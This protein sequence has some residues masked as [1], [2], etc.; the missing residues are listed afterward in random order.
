MPSQSPSQPPAST[1]LSDATGAG[2]QALPEKTGKDDEAATV[3]ET[4]EKRSDAD[5]SRPPKVDI[6]MQHDADAPQYRTLPVRR[7]HGGALPE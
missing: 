1:R 5:A 2:G 3:A 7:T 4:E 6:A